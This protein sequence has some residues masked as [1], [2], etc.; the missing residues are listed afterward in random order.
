M[1]DRVRAIVR[2]LRK[3]KLGRRTYARMR[4]D[5]R[6]LVRDRRNQAEETTTTLSLSLSLGRAFEGNERTGKK[7]KRGGAR[8][9]GARPVEDRE[10]L[11]PARPGL[12]VA[13]ARVRGTREG[14]SRERGESDGGGDGRRGRARRTRARE[15]ER[16]GDIRE[17]EG[18]GRRGGEE[19]GMRRQRE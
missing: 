16:G 8:T 11:T 6:N 19:R 1:R 3:E 9:L 2:S 7:K 4:I 17:Q 10:R 14:D 5:C 13:A 15:R 12:F 18:E